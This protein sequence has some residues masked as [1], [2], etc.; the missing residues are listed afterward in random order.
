[1]TDKNNVGEYYVDFDDETETY[2]VFHT[3]DTKAVSSFATVERANVI[4]EM[5]NNEEI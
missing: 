5:M 2:C 1:M 4:C 3:E